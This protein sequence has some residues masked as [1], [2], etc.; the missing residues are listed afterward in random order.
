M[1]D[2]AFDFAVF[3]A[4]PFALLLAGQLA[5]TGRK[6]VCLV[7]ENWSPYRLPRGFDVSVIPAT[8]PE[9]WAMLRRG[10]R[11][12]RQLVAGIG[13]NLIERVDPLFIGETRSSTERLGHLKWVALGMGFPAEWA[14]DRPY[15][16]E[17]R[18]CRIRDASMLVGGRIEPALDGWLVRQEVRRFDPAGTALSFPRNAAPLLTAAGRSFD[19]ETIVLAD[20]DAILSQ[21]PAAERPELLRP[22]PATSLVTETGKP[23]AAPLI[24]FLD[25]RTTLQQRGRKGGQIAAIALDDPDNALARIGAS[26]AGGDNPRRAGQTLF[27]TVATADEAPAIGRVGKNRLVA[28][29]GL[30]ASAAFFSP[31]VA[32]WLAGAAADDEREWFGARDINKPGARQAVAESEPPSLELAS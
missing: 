31:L 26:L 12:T 15:L 3:G 29:A 4:T 18:T 10:I 5:A 28:I 13:S 8:R 6:R 22:M 2:G 19:V 16:P 1:A 25:R 11:E 7:G 14:I 27:R 30:G 17:T 20:D 23:L 24:H 9:T 32:R 21:L